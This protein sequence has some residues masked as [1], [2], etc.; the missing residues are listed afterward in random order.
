[1]VTIVETMSYYAFLVTIMAAAAYVLH[2]FLK[3]TWLTKA[4]LVLNAAGAVCMLIAVVNRTMQVGRLPLN[5]VFEYLIVLSFAILCVAVFISLRFR[6]Y[7]PVAVILVICAVL[8]GISFGKTDVGGPLLPALQSNWRVSHVMT[9]IISYSAFALA[10]GV[11]VF[12]LIIMPRKEPQGGIPE[13]KK[14]RGV[15]LERM[16]FNSVV[17]GFIFL[18]LLIITGAIWAEEAWGSWWTWDP[19]ETWALITW[20]IYAIY[21]HLRLRPAWRG[22]KGCYLAVIGFVAVLFTLLGVTYIFGGLHS[23]G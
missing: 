3:R 13:E 2:L 22:R 21:L 16:M 19:K 7:G 1:M 10:A 23:Y 11:A 9:A 12:Y 8:I 5:S 18:T 14:N 15:F 4:G 20:I 17:V 6:S